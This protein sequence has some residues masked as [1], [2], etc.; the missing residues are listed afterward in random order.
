MRKIILSTRIKPVLLI[1]LCTALL[2]LC[3]SFGVLT[4]NTRS[5]SGAELK[6]VP[7]GTERIEVT[8]T[9]GITSAMTY[10]QMKNYVTVTA[11]SQDGTV[12]GSLNPSDFEVVGDF[13]DGQ[14]TTSD[15]TVTVTGTE[16]TETV[17]IQGFTADRSAV[18][19]ISATYNGGGVLRSYTPIN[20][21]LQQSLI[22][23]T[24]TTWEGTTRSLNLN[25]EVVL[26]GNLAPSTGGVNAEFSK[27]VTVRYRE[28]GSNTNITCICEI[29]GIQPAVPQSI[30]V[31]PNNVVTALEPCA[32][33]DLIVTVTYVG[34][35][36]VEIPFNAYSVQYMQ[37]VDGVWEVYPDA[38]G[39]IYGDGWGR[40]QVTYSEAGTQ[41][42]GSNSEY[43]LI[44]VSRVAVT[45]PTFSSAGSDYDYTD[46]DGVAVGE[47]QTISLN[48]FYDDT[49][50]EIKGVSYQ[51]EIEDAS[52]QFNSTNGSITVTDAGI[53]TVTVAL[54]EEA[55]AYFFRNDDNDDD[56]R[57]IEITYEIYPVEPPIEIEWSENAYD[58]ED[59]KWD[60][61][62]IVSFELLKNYGNGEV[63][64]TYRRTDDSTTTGTAE[65]PNLPNET[66]T[67]TLTVKVEANGNFAAF[68]GELA[69]FTVG[70]RVIGLPT[71]NNPEVNDGNLVY[72]GAEQEA[73]ITYAGGEG[74]EGYLDVTNAGG[75]VVGDDYY[76][77]TFTIKDQYADEA[78]WDS[79]I[80]DSLG[81]GESLVGNKLTLTYQITKLS[82]AIP[83]FGTNGTITTPYQGSPNN[84][85]AQEQ[86]LGNWY[87]SAGFAQG[88]TSPVTVKISGGSGAV[89]ADSINGTVTATNAG[90]YTVTVSL[91]DTNNLQW[92]NG[93]TADLEFEYIINKATVTIP[94]AGSKTYTG[95]ALTSDLADT[96]FYT[97]SQETDWVNADDYDVTLSLTDA[98]NYKWSDGRESES[99]MVTFTID[100]LPVT[101]DWDESTFSFIYDGDS[102]VASASVGNKIGQD[103]VS[104][105]ISGAQT[106][107]NTNGASYTATIIGLTGDQAGNYTLT[108]ASGSTTQTFTIAPR[109]IGIVWDTTTHVYDG[110]SWHPEA[111]SFMNVIGGDSVGTL[112]YDG[113][114]T[115]AGTNYTV[116]VTAVSNPNYTVS[117][118]TN[119]STTFTIT[120]YE[121]D[122]PGEMANDDFTYTAAPQTYLPDGFNPTPFGEDTMTISG[123]VQTNAGTYTV[124]VSLASGNYKWSDTD[125][126][127]AVVFTD[128]FVIAKAELTV[129]WTGTET[130]YDGIAF[131]PSYSLS[132]WKEQDNASDYTWSWTITGEK[133]T[134][135]SA[136]DAGSYHAVLLISAG[137]SGFLNYYLS[138]NETDFVIN[139]AQVDVSEIVSEPKGISGNEASDDRRIPFTE[140]GSS[141][142]IVTAYPELYSIGDFS[143]NNDV[144]DY[145]VVLT[146][147]DSDNYEWTGYIEAGAGVGIYD[148]VYGGEITIRYAIT[149]QQFTLGIELAD[150]WVYGNDANN[151][152]A[153][154]NNLTGNT[155]TFTYYTW[156][157]D[158]QRFDEEG[159]STLPTN[160]GRYLVV[161]EVDDGNNYAGTE[162]RKEF[163]ITPETVT[164]KISVSDGTY[165]SWSGASIADISGNADSGYEQIEKTNISLIFESLTSGV[166]LVNGIPQ[167][168]G[169]Y[170]VTAQFAT[171]AN[172][173]GN[174][175]L[176]VAYTTDDAFT[177]SPLVLT[178]TG[179]DGTTNVY[180]GQGSSY[181]PTVNGANVQEKFGDTLKGLALEYTV[182]ANEGSS[183]TGA[184][185]VD[186]GSYTVK[187][188]GIGNKNYT[189]DGATGITNDF[190]ITPYKIDFALGVTD[191]VYGSFV[192][193]RNI[194]VNYTTETL[195]NESAE[196]RF[197][198]T[199]KLNST[200]AYTNKFEAG[201]YTVTAT[202]KNKNY[203]LA[204]GET[205]LTYDFTIEKATISDIMWAD[206]T[207]T[208]NNSNQYDGKFATAAGVYGD[209]TLNLTEAIT[210]NGVTAEFINAGEYTF[211]AGL[212]KE[213]EYNYQFAEGLVLTNKYVI[214]PAAI[215]ITLIKQT[216]TYNG[217][218]NFT[219]GAESG[220]TYS[221]TDGDTFGVDLDDDLT[222]TIQ[223][224]TRNAKAYNVSGVLDNPNFK[225]TGW[226]NTAGAFEITPAKLEVKFTTFD[227]GTYGSANGTDF[228]VVSVLGTGDNKDSLGGSISYEGVEPG[229]TWQDEASPAGEYTVTLTITNNNYVFENGTRSFTADSKLVVK[230]YVIESVEWEDRTFTYTGSNQYDGKFATAEGVNGDGTLD[231]AEAITQNGVT[232]EFKNAGEYTFTA[233]LETEQANN[234]QFA[235]SLVLTKNYTINKA[236]LTLSVVQGYSGTYDG[237]EHN[238]LN[239][240]YSATTVDGSKATWEYRLT[241]SVDGDWQEQLT[242]KDAGTYKVDYRVTATNHK[243]VTDSVTVQIYKKAISIAINGTITYGEALPGVDVGIDNNGT[244]TTKVT[245]GGYAD[246]ENFGKLGIKIASITA[247][248]YKQG[249]DAKDYPLT[250]TFTDESSTSNY[251]VT[252]DSGTLKV[253]RR[254]ITVHIKDITDN[255]NKDIID[256]NDIENPAYS[257]TGETYDGEVPFYLSTTATK[258]SGI[259]TDNN[260]YYI[261]PTVTNDNN[262]SVTFT[263]SHKN[264]TI[265]NVEYAA[266][267]AYII[268]PASTSI[269]ITPPTSLVYNGKEKTHYAKSSDGV[270]LSAEY[271][272]Y[273]GDVEAWETNR[274]DLSYF[275]SVGNTAPVNVGY[276]CVVF[277]SKNPNYEAANAMQSFVVTKKTI[278][279]VITADNSTYDGLQ[280]EAEISFR[281]LVAADEAGWEYNT[282]YILTYKGIEG[283]TYESADA[284]KNAGS[285]TVTV[286]L[287]EA[288]GKNY[289]LPV[290]YDDFEI[291]KVEL[292]IKA[293][294]KTVTYGNN[295]D[296]VTITYQYDGFVNGEDAEGLGVKPGFTTDYKPGDD[297]GSKFEIMPNGVEL[298][299]YNIKYAAGILTVEKRAITVTI[300]DQSLVY[301]GATADVKSEEDVDYTISGNGGKYGNDDLIIELSASGKDVGTY[302]I[303][304]TAG[305][306]DVNNYSITY[307]GNWESRAGILTITPKALTIKAKDVNVTYGDDAVLS[308]D[309]T[310][311]VENEN[312]SVLGGTLAFET[313]DSSGKSYAK[314]DSAGSTYTIEPSGLTSDNYD[315]TFETGT[316][317]VQ[318]RVVTVNVKVYGYEYNYDKAVPVDV[319]FNNVY[320]YDNGI[321]EHEV[322]Y[323]GSANDG[324][325]IRDYGTEEPVKAG[326]YTAKVRIT[327]NNYTFA[328][329]K[330][331]S[332]EYDYTI[333]KRTIDVNWEN[334]VI[335]YT[336][337][338]N[339]YTNMLKVSSGTGSLSFADEV[340]TI[341]SQTVILGNGSISETASS[342]NNYTITVSSDIYTTPVGTYAATIQINASH[343]YNYTFDEGDATTI[344]FEISADAN[345]LKFA[346]GAD[347]SE[348]LD[349]TYGEP[350]EWTLMKGLDEFL[351]LTYGNVSDVI[352]AYA[353][354]TGVGTA[355]TAT[356]TSIRPTDAGEYYVR[357]Y[358]PGSVSEDYGRTEFI[359]AEFTINKAVL[360]APSLTENESAYIGSEMN[361]PIS[362]FDA[363]TMGIS[364]SVNFTA[365]GNNITLLATTVGTYE[366]IITLKQPD[367]HMW[368][369]GT[370]EGIT[371]SWKVTK[372]L[373]NKITEFNIP[374]SW[375]YGDT[376]TISA[377]AVF[378]TP[379]VYYV[380]YAE[381]DLPGSTDDLSSLSWSDK[382]P[383]NTGRYLACAFVRDTNENYNDAWE[384]AIFEINNAELSV[385][386]TG[387]EGIYDGKSHN[388]V[389]SSGVTGVGGVTVTA[390][391][392]FSDSQ[393][394]EYSTG[395]PIVKN[396]TDGAKTIYYIVSAPNYNDY[397]GQITVNIEKKDL[398]I[399]V[400]DVS[401]IYGETTPSTFSLAHAGLVSGD[402][403]PA[404]G[405][406]YKIEKDGVAP[407]ET[408]LP[409]GVYTVSLNPISALSNYDINYV[410]GKLNVAR[411]SIAVNIEDQGS[412][413][414][415]VISLDQSKV[416]VDTAQLVDGDTVADLGI[417][418]SKADGT[419][420]GAYPITG[421]YVSANYVVVFVPGVYTISAKAVSVTIT[422]NGGVYGGTITGATATVDGLIA[423]DEGSVNVVLTYT[424]TA[425]DGT[426]YNGT[427][428]PTKAGAYT[429]TAALDSTNYTLTGVTTA[430]FIVERATVTVPDAG[431][432]TYTGS[433]LKS[434]LADT[435]EYTVAQGDNWT[436]AGNYNVTLTL[437]DKN[438]YKW[439]TTNASDDVTV[440]FAIT[441]AANSFTSQP[442]I[443]GWTYSEDANKPYGAAAQFGTDTIVYM[444]SAEEYGEYTTTVPTEA[445]TYYVKAFIAATNNYAGAES[446]AVEFTIAKYTNNAISGLTFADSW[447]YNTT[448]TAP[449]ASAAFGTVQYK[450]AVDDGSTPAEDI[451]EWSD[452]MPTAAGSYWICAYVDGT[453]NY[454]GAAEYKQFTITPATL[455]V[456][457]VAGYNGTYDGTAHNGRTGGTASTVDGSAATWQ[458]SLTGSGDWQTDQLTFTDAGTYT[459]H[460]KVTAANHSDATGEFTVNIY[461]ASLTVIVG[462]DTVNYG[463][464]APSTFDVTYN[465]FVGTDS[466]S[467]LGGSLKFTVEDYSA[468]APAGSY[469]VKASGLTSD[470][471]V[472]TY[473]DGTLQVVKINATV[474]ITPNG[475]VYGGMITGATATVS[476][477]TAAD[478]GSVNVVLTYTGTAY[479]GTQYNGTEV[480]TKAGAYTVTATLDSANYT[481]TGVTTAAFIVERATVTVPDAGSKPFAGSALKSNLADTS[482]YTVTQGEDWTNAGNY[483]V[484]LTL[485]DKNNYK[486][487]TTN[488]SDDVTVTF[489]ITQA[490]NKFTAQ[491]VING[492]TY[493]E[494]A[495]KPYGAEA[496]FGTE[497]IVY[498]Y[499]A[500]EYGEYT[501]TVPAE[502]G[503]YYVKAF[504]AATDNY[505][506]AESD[507]VEFTIAKYTS[508]AISGLTFESSW[509]YNT[510]PTAPSASATFGTVQYKYA[511][512][513]G[514]TL[515]EDIAV[516]ST[517]IPKSVGDY[518]ICAYVDGTDNYNG[519]AEYK[520]FTIT[521]AT[522]TVTGVAG[523]NGTYDGTAHSGR[524]GGIVTTVD[525]SAATWE[526][527]LTGSGNWQIDQFTFKNAGTYTV[528]YRVIAA[529]HNAV[530]GSFNVNINKASLTVIV[531]NATINYGED[532]PG[533]F[534]VTYNGFVGTDSES[535]L[536]GAIKFS[537]KDY[538]PGAPA[539]SYIVSASGLTSDNYD[540]TYRNGILF[541]TS[542]TIT[543]TIT[544][545][546]GV[547]G[548]TIIGAT[549]TLNGVPAGADIEPILTYTGTAYDGTIYNSTEVPTKAGSYTVTV[550]L[551]DDSY[552]LSGV[553]SSIFTIERATVTVP[554]AGSK[555]Y[556]GSALKSDLTDTSEYTV[557]QGEDW[558]N[559][560]NYNVTLTLRDKNNY[561]WSTTG[562]GSDVTVT[563]TITQAE[564]KFTAQPVI[565]GWTYSE[566]ANAPGGAEALFGTETIVYMYSA[567]ADG[568]YTTTVPTEAGTYYVKAFITETSNYTGAESDAVMFEIVIHA[569]AATPELEFE[570]SVYSGAEQTNE[571]TGYDASIMSMTGTAAVSTSDGIT[572]LKATNAGV[573]TVTIT[574]KNEN[575][576]FSDGSTSVTL[577][578]TIS[579]QSVD[580]PTR[581]EGEWII[582][583]GN[584]FEYI[585]VGFDDDLMKITGNKIT[586]PGNYTVTV[587]L[588]DT[589]NY[590]WDDGTDD[591]V[592]F[593][594]SVAE[595][596]ISLLW[597]IILLI[598]VIVIEIILLIAGIVRRRKS[599]NDG[600]GDGAGKGNAGFAAA[601]AFTVMSDVII[602]SHL[603]ACCVLGGIA[604][605]LLVCVLI[606]YLKKKKSAEDKQHAKKA[607]PAEAN[608]K[609]EQNGK[610]NADKK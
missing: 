90:S 41:I 78:E 239:D 358:Y 474:T 151:A 132:G 326:Q 303:T 487:S 574:L 150:T 153:V 38:E 241:E 73:S 515:P 120:P 427:E 492:W 8:Y 310:G 558:T 170:S 322:Y 505:A 208:Y 520:Q 109:S 77:V 147:V 579:R 333:N 494:D 584:T 89:S 417:T 541:V 463:E 516:W 570:T 282:H 271:Y 533:T 213:Q 416:S 386:A 185:A 328:D 478:E 192:G 360:T 546:G 96:D 321:V 172:P 37:N 6:A 534:D 216:V 260:K 493:S 465:G 404:S 373:N 168:A 20:Y 316:L 338:T 200:E 387:Y 383:E 240:G 391:W 204:G 230:K 238:A 173:N 606:V 464:D 352:F 519:A 582:A 432:K 273:T 468:G 274:N 45:Q 312:N 580:K 34:G 592:V 190:T 559:A 419:A 309:Y 577:S 245:G 371:L 385:S 237:K 301:A 152:P 610:D 438:N 104:F 421:T 257:I 135:N 434:D 491:P 375:T 379:V 225:V 325:V 540:I 399:R 440:T 398:T 11:Y 136:V 457:G 247:D 224:L 565:N 536:G 212:E 597:L 291:T 14:N 7:E 138:G 372:A 543:A 183:L 319:T 31:T 590:V 203:T 479:D 95:G 234:Y 415:E 70:Q 174:Y 569:D 368:T 91:G 265:N 29:T 181:Q 489:T 244:F 351:V 462:N 402:S 367:N 254:E 300:H 54:R 350:G 99:I 595:K 127:S 10:A 603:T 118:G 561:K 537:V 25:N 530:T 68:E 19:S 76:T 332:G 538:V 560:G 259:T 555:T 484:T 69:T 134:D 74:D 27:N 363:Q 49:I 40:V 517:A 3:V 467:D 499:S 180:A 218:A 85:T 600:S 140:N 573:Y 50:M 142:L 320:E 66:G 331:Y 548:G 359:Y 43:Y 231:L 278:S 547:Y 422:P 411:K 418:L 476:G 149:Y 197:S 459:V 123:N 336:A 88:E 341:V 392:K 572:V 323:K 15:F 608:V 17:T 125:D 413:Y 521:Q 567:A 59:L 277:T 65:D 549:A 470:N 455:T 275:E 395:M 285:Y 2:I 480:P 503:T 453:D 226:I 62:D 525:G 228:N 143:S 551:S 61:D 289:T 227:G 75:T 67:Y 426:Q 236:G 576:T 106:N 270:E 575:Y 407:S 589:N 568:E 184:A 18:R 111:A 100:P 497:T 178:V 466:E 598:V 393:N 607:D 460:Y 293:D 23:V 280:Y 268:I 302:A 79:A 317:T 214:T 311:F 314:G 498:M 102:H 137:E 305:G 586:E 439:S 92:T 182:T 162:A 249:D 171:G 444:Y 189:L 523:Y 287:T 587:T 414:G 356:Y 258:G 299:N 527:S 507:A 604:V 176:A 160:V 267:G 449:S 369:D 107:A 210:Q 542:I 86:S 430:A 121:V 5:A 364:T 337:G 378:G 164:V 117:G 509:V 609:A 186:V 500:E 233:G 346:E 308:V 518:W 199:G 21:L 187:V 339:E 442:S 377:D 496:L 71:L 251:A 409:A 557:T 60:R 286:T 157:E 243:T 276:Y 219:F 599:D 148:T 263:G 32:A 591:P 113:A 397:S 235:E 454:N 552:T 475:G 163:T 488:A 535:D 405:L 115:D 461:Q 324:S 545:N 524:T 428:V 255:Y 158:A 155:A 288:G 436:A 46:S 221:I 583:D 154:T 408:I 261:Y 389:V 195:N 114:K 508:N 501:T 602:P 193:D 42:S 401:I 342:S 30:S 110:E 471:Y 306:K 33:G 47:P 539:N 28:G 513:D 201:N 161:A 554:D 532:A 122:K 119:I 141:H 441:Q 593:S 1:A 553:T 56:L 146:L 446:D 156:D 388:A 252:A 472:I 315:I 423:A 345:I 435:S 167:N 272:T 571:I 246:G 130:T 578:W 526:Y 53:Y 596:E 318:K 394:G 229:D 9:G 207:F 296:T 562:A 458:Y 44:Q 266:V 329:D 262:Y 588:R 145:E 469:T 354:N 452:V 191:N 431:S 327:D 380:E 4:A 531:G 284:P 81:E 355:E 55:Q 304:G 473:T 144:G 564:N 222:F 205:E 506:G 601:M 116:T 353:V 93:T 51:G 13:D 335:A 447:V 101:I 481:L 514:S 39:Y 206:R 510:T 198:Y 424:G 64:Y 52:A 83:T 347:L 605:I 194:T 429:V 139:K 412:V 279:V 295:I 448:P 58:G 84:G 349:W 87:P 381:G 433:A 482:E 400:E 374:E 94:D 456:T 129:T 529:N 290:S 179:W 188:T 450:Y 340:L 57:E 269:T 128:K 550:S 112:R 334:S 344:T 362:G 232:A 166:E 281:D 165:G 105:V 390:T 365:S 425:Y 581:A 80:A 283:T 217:T 297:A 486:W 585:P 48:E 36:Q 211:T 313:E 544:P 443:T 196:I 292:T 445:G 437:K 202:I 248:G 361:N 12:L 512:D 108:D 495:N 483:N 330:E 24:A 485:K 22:S 26:E 594:W 223:D 215:S 384:F 131:T 406:T 298:D 250:W 556:T 294:N 511:A 35:M 220:K 348:I 209:G 133:V 103:D 256:L 343:F 566:D 98:T 357:I 477:L 370:S 169:E 522:L 490:E 451:A 410:S 159:S 376:V 396:A 382:L 16:I 366:V 126:R 403:I 502:A 528:Y 72:N 175:T 563:F 253:A 63:T 124:T 242:F 504:I 264:V 82:I 307:S 177:I 420:V 97:V